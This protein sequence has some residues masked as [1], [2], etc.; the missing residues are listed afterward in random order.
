MPKAPQAPPGFK[1]SFYDEIDRNKRNSILLA[2]GVFAVLVALIFVIGALVTEGDPAA[3]GAIVLFGFIFTLLYTFGS[4]YYGDQIVLSSTGAKPLDDS[5][6]KGRY[7]KNTVEGLCIAAQ[8]PVPKIYVIESTEMNAFA[9]GRDPQHASIAFTT[10]IIEKL[11]RVELEG[12]AAHELSH[13]SN[14]DIRFAMVVAVMVG[15]VA[16]LSQLLLRSYWFGGG[17]GNDRKGG[18]GIVLLY[19]FGIILA[20][21][22]PFLVR[23]VQSAISR[24]RELLADASAAKF[25]R[26]PEGLASALEKIGGSNK[27]NMP[28]NEAVSHLFFVDPTKTDLDALYAT[29]PSIEQ[30]V[31]TLRAM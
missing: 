21:V 7:V 15:L 25:T 10:A 9:T 11:N 13:V 14:Y 23:L 28:V 24:K 5:T 16:I 22:A 26:Y 3:T 6:P 8:L 29:H 30:R 4:Y 18:G 12:V 17:R 19:I 2:A 1:T 20:L 31:K 27:G